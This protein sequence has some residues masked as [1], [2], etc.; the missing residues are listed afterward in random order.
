[1]GE[2]L[3]PLVKTGSCP[4][5]WFPADDALCSESSGRATDATIRSGVKCKI[6]LQAFSSPS[7]DLHL[8]PQERI[9]NYVYES[10]MHEK[11]THIEC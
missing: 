5:R 6:N 7:G 4:N 1:M 10:V 11:A 9:K 2:N 3:L 8:Q